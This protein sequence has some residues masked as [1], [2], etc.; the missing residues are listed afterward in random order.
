M[1]SDYPEIGTEIMGDSGSATG[2]N[3][4]FIIDNITWIDL[5]GATTKLTGAMTE[6]VT[7]DSAIPEPSTWSMM[8]LGFAAFGFRLCGLSPWAAGWFCFARVR[9]LRLASMPQHRIRELT[10][11]MRYSSMIL[12]FKAPGPN[13]AASEVTRTEYS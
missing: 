8:C 4:A 12:G 1:P 3:T 5:P 7:G 13:R 2:H 11:F 9:A 10:S 6:L